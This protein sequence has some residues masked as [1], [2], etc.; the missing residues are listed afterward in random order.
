MAAPACDV[1][2]NN[3]SPVLAKALPPQKKSICLV[4]TSRGHHQAGRVL[5]K[6]SYAM[7]SQRK[8]P[9]KADILL[10]MTINGEWIRDHWLLQS[11]P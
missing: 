2:E 9:L 7:Q 8:W 4:V 6:A 5:P 11:S 1:D 3:D 10:S